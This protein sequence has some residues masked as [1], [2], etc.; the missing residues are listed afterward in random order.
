M[1]VICLLGIKQAK[2]LSQEKGHKSTCT[3]RASGCKNFI[4]RCNQEQKYQNQ[5]QEKC[6]EICLYTSEV[7]IR[8]RNIS[9][10]WREQF[11]HPEKHAIHY[12]LNSSIRVK[13]AV[14][15][16]FLCCQSIYWCS[17]GQSSEDS[18]G[19]ILFNFKEFYIEMCGD[20]ILY[21]I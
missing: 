15:L 10:L 4:Q 12:E 19:V 17:L 16:V 18:H 9:L 7:A 5:K 13:C 2:N 3:V 20:L 1:W 14:I 6:L 8:K 11:W 21:G